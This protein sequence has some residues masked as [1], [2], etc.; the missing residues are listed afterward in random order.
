MLRRIMCKVELRDSRQLGMM[1]CGSWHAENLKKLR[2]PA[3]RK[4]VPVIRRLD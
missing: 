1:R 2:L 4:S 3:A